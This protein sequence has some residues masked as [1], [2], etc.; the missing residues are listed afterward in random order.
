ML[1]KEDFPGLEPGDIV[2]L[3]HPENEED[4]E[5]KVPRV[6]QMI[7]KSSIYP[8]NNLPKPLNRDTLNVEKSVA[9]TFSLP[10]YMDVIVTKVDKRSVTLDSVELTFKEQYVG[11]SEM[12]RLSKSLRDSCVYVNK[13]V[14]LCQGQVRCTVN[15]LW[16]Q[17]DRVSSGIVTNETKIV[18][19]SPT[20]M[21]YLFI[22]MSSEMWQYDNHGELFF[23]K[24]CGFLDQLF[25]KWE[26][27][28]SSHEVTIVLFSR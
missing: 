17:G 26:K 10:N 2:E 4:G 3:Y 8:D 15:E 28:G 21:V 20:A 6:L 19:R 12:W 1:H 7:S 24:A 5:I 25:D 27:K 11:R 23:E 9:E 22:Q 14:D 16:S 13:K 18:F